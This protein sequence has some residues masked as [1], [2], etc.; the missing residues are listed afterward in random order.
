[1]GKTSKPL[2]NL[3]KGSK[4]GWGIFIGFSFQI[5]NKKIRRFWFLSSIYWFSGLL[6]IQGILKPAH[7]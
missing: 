3:W 2:K 5:L 7:E 6:I 4:M 1:M